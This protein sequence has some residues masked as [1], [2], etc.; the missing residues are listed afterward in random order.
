MRN[1][2]PFRRITW[3]AAALLLVA[4][5]P[6]SALQAAP[7]PLGP[8]PAEAAGPT[9][10]PAAA[11]RAYLATIPAAAKV[12]SDAYFEGGY[13]LI[14]WNF[15]LTSGIL[16]LML[17]ARWSV[18]WRDLAKQ[19]SSSRFPQIIFYAVIYNLVAWALS[20]PLLV[21]QDF[22]REHQY[23][24]ATQN[25]GQWFGDQAKA[26]ALSTIFFPLV[27]AALYAVFRR[28]PRTWWLW[29]SLVMISLVIVGIA[30]SPTFIE[31]IFNKYTPIQD[32]ALR[33]PILTMARANQ[34]PVTDVYIV[35]ASKQ[36]KRVS[37]NVSGILG[38]A[39]IALNDN[40][41]NRCSLPEIRQV[42]AH[43]MGHY[44]LNH[45][46]KLVLELACVFFVMFA[47]A[48]VIFD[49][50]ILRYGA[51]WGVEGIA[52]PAGL[53]L[54]SL[55]I[56]ALFFL[57]TPLSNSLTRETEAEADAFGINVSREP[58]GFAQSAIKLGEYRK[59][60]PSPF[61]EFVFFDHPSGRARIR[62]AM[63]WKAAH[64][65]AGG[66]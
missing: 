29:G 62:M 58:D 26:V 6:W 28:A 56:T 14:L 35:D 16:L 8:I 34:I 57:Y 65:P 59:M 39:R 20:F 36:T 2:F 33:D 25:F 55:I 46:Y 3:L 42:M 31:P 52:D 54:L 49:R 64:L 7:V 44:V 61:E 1:L 53:P 43:E 15:L 48:K 50:A 41:V 5:F 47:L 10:D 19:F 12:R 38:S 13:W 32:P 27:V 51:R 17:N 63:E 23:G 30:L 22:F 37:A 18:A 21:Y 66:E 60:D 11:T 45:I 4:C 9:I 40:L 24:M